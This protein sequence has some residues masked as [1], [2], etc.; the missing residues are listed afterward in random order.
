MVGIESLNS[1]LS[2]ETGALLTQFQAA[3]PDRISG[4]ERQQV[5][6]AMIEEQLSEHDRG[7]LQ[8]YF[9][10]LLLGL[11]NWGA[12][13]MEFGGAGCDGKI[14]A[15]KDGQKAPLENSAEV[16][17]TGAGILLQNLLTQLQRETLIQCRN[18]D[19]SYSIAG[20]NKTRIRFRADAYFEMGTLAANF[21]VIDTE[22][23]AIETYGFNPFVLR[24]LNLT[25]TKEG[26]ILVTGI[27]GSGKS[28]TLDALVDYNNQIIGGHIV[29][30][31]SPLEFVHV[32]KRCLIRHREVGRDTGTFKSGIVEALRQDPDIIVVGEMRDPETIVAA[33]EAADSG[34]KVISTLHTSSAVESVERIIAETPS[35]E[36]ERVRLRLAAILKCVI[37]QKLVPAMNGGRVLAKE[38]MVVTPS[39]QAAIKNNNTEEVYQMI[40]EG[41]KYGMCTMEQDLKRL[42]ATNRISIQTAENF[43]NNKRMMQQLL[44]AA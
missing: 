7:L 34:H 40:T 22:L 3:I 33:L 37:S 27:T 12:S 20:E 19:F 21:R 1:A 17:E 41:K 18:L 36:Q 6:S 11:R 35:I 8:A 29:V 31:S 23:R 26:L 10:Q 16:T 43:A 4:I 38:V 9:D 28:S 44:Q 14:W 2:R 5:I 32:S 13:D 24:M 42:A 39:I 25:H 30:I 15:R